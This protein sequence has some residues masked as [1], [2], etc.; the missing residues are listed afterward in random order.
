M[1]FDVVAVTPIA[2]FE[3]IISIFLISQKLV[4]LFLSWLFFITVGIS[5][6]IVC[7]V[8]DPVYMKI[9]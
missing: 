3:I 8:V 2:L 7:R 1:N 6:Y 5:V 9:V 4:V